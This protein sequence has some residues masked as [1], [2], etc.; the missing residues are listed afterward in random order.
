VRGRRAQILSIEILDA[1]GDR[2]AIALTP[3]QG[4]PP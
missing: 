1:H 4:S 2:I 3:S